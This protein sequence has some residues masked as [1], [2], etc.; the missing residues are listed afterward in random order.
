MDDDEEFEEAPRAPISR[1][2]R[3]GLSVALLLALAA[4]GSFGFIGSFGFLGVS[5]STLVGSDSPAYGYSRHEHLASGIAL[6]VSSFAFGFFTLIDPDD[7]RD[8]VPLRRLRKVAQSVS[9]IFELNFTAGLQLLALY[10]FET[11]YNA[12]FG[13]SIIM[14]GVFSLGSMSNTLLMLQTSY[15]TLKSTVAIRSPSKADGSSQLVRSTSVGAVAKALW[16][17]LADNVR[18][19]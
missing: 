7:D 19:D 14:M 2:E 9:T 1:C 17:S 11:N 6:L 12:T 3:F 15:S 4:F 8:S 10:G 18:P 16:P 5:D 13:V